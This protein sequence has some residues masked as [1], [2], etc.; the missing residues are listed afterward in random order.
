V[1]TSTRH[2]GFE[3]IDDVET[4]RALLLRLREALPRKD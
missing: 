4:V 2:F 1:Q 3:H